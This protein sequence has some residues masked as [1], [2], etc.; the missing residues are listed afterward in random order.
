MKRIFVWAVLMVVSLAGMSQ[1]SP[2]RDQKLKELIDKAVNN[3]PKLKELEEQLKL[4]DVRAELIQSN[5]KPT[6]GADLSYQYLNPLSEISFNG[7]KARF[8]PY[9]NFNTSLTLKQ[10]VY[11]FGKTKP[12]WRPMTSS[13]IIRL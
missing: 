10:L 1:E 9:N 5:Y 12:A 7:T 6:L 13:T 11:D 8:Q 2:I 3:F 4:N